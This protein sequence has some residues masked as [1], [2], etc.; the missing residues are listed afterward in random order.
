MKHL[1]LLEGRCQQWILS[2]HSGQS[3]PLNLY[4]S[5]WGLVSGRFAIIVVEETAETGPCFDDALAP[6]H[7]LVCTD[8]VATQSLVLEMVVL[9]V[10][11]DSQ[12]K[13]LF[14]K[15]NDL[16]ETRRARWTRRN[17]LQRRSN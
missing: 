6:S 10:L 13:M 17:A 11:F 5:F 7:G 8:D 4:L 12:T 9:H 2:R 16:V 3:D 1:N 15:G 14:S